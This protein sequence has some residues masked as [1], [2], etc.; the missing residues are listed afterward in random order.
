MVVKE[1]QVAG[2]EIVDFTPPDP[3]EALQIGSQL[4]YADGGTFNNFA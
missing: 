2:H 3:L 4:L 1:L